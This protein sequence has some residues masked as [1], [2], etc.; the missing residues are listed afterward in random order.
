MTPATRVPPAAP[1]LVPGFHKGGNPIGQSQGPRQQAGR[2]TTHG[3]SPFRPSAAAKA[4]ERQAAG[5]R[6]AL[7]PPEAGAP[8][9]AAGGHCRI[10]QDESILFQIFIGYFTREIPLRGLV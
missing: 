2:T 3:R 10:N 8:G 5:E 7:R 1:C 9:A 4:A 6:G